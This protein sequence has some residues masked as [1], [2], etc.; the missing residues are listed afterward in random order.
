MKI[1][2]RYILN[3]F[4]VTFF[5]CYISL[6]GIYVIFDVTANVSDFL[7]SGTLMQV[8]MTIPFY[9]F[10][11]TFIIIDMF[12]PMLVLLAAMAT[13]SYMVRYH[14]VIAL[15]AMGISPGRILVPLIIGALGLSVLFTG[16]REFYIP[17]KLISFSL[18]PVELIQN[19]DTCNVFR[20]YDDKSLIS[21][22]GDK[23]L[24]EGRVLIKPSITLSQNLNRY[25]NR[26]VAAEGRF[27]EA[28][29]NHT[30]G[31]I[32]SGL[33]SSTELL[34]NSSLIDPDLNEKIIYSPKDTDWLAEDEIFIATSLKPL[35][36][37][38]GEKWSL[39]GS[40]FEL[41]EALN[42]PA[43]GRESVPL[44]IRVH[45]R[46]LRPF[47]DILPL[48]LGVP[49]LFIRTDKN[50][51]WVIFQ[52]MILAGFYVGV[53]YVCAYWGEKLN[54]PTLGI[55][56]A[57]FLFIPII[58]VILGELLKKESKSGKCV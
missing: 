31:W 51:L 10:I 41:R 35:H 39:Y 1:F 56:G 55:W 20:S 17:S 32:L 49:F 46:F 11:N 5:L 57:L 21:I 40:V 33:S 7:S 24:L 13:I 30:S 50:F 54:A 52:G 12:F 9:Y 23:M 2:D 58:S 16:I 3:K 19:A 6:V 25:G 18:K 28:N 44:T 15:L 48:F 27:V 43:F 8:L 36:L 42:N 29:N 34:K 53:Q 22:D 37:I 26:I 14:E 38:T 47:T 45:S 4:C